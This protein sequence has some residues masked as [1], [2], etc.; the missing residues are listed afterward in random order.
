MIGEV[1]LAS[2]RTAAVLRRCAPGA[3][4]AASAFAALGELVAAKRGAAR[5][6]GGRRPD[7]RRRPDRLL[8]ARRGRRRGLKAFFVRKERKE[9]GLQRWI[10]GPAIEPGERALV[11]E[12][13]VT[14]G[15]SLVTAIERLREEGVEIA[16]ALAV[17]RPARRRRA[18]RSRSA[19]RRPALR[20]A[21]HDR[22]RLSGPPGPLGATICGAMRRL[23][24]IAAVLFVL[25]PA[26]AAIAYVPS[27]PP[28]TND[29]IVWRHSRA[30]GIPSK[31]RLVKGVNLSTRRR[32]RAS[33]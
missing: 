26:T 32:S 23:L 17:R 20:L 3:A 21:L 5:R 6:R 33:P 29:P 19:R 4:A 9:H 24:P 16:G 10:E 31:G 2:G 12:D 27:P 28:P 25:S 7:A 15:G 30:I 11:V 8:G 22:R 1:T 14:S 18:R 13:V